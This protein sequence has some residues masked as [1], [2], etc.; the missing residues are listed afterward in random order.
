LAVYQADALVLRGREYGETDRLLTLFA[1]EQGKIE[2]VAKGARRPV[3][4]QRGGAQLFTYAD[5][6]LYGRRAPA[7]VRQAQPRETFNHLWGDWEKSRGAAIMAEFLDAATPW[8]EPAPELFRLTLTGFFLLADLPPDLLVTA[9]A[10]KVLKN[11]GYWADGAEEG[12]PLKAGSRA[13]VR[14]LLLTPPR[15]LSRLRWSKEMQAE[16]EGFVRAWAEERLERRL[17][18]WNTVF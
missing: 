12:A 16:I 10:L 17:I 6:L 14:R 15:Q 1:R 7:I 9:Y 5:F 3:S 18:A 4:K 8:G 13:M 2:A 11:Q